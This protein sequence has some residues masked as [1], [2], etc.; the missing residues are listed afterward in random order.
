ME[1]KRKKASD[2]AVENS[3]WS[4]NEFYWLVLAVGAVCMTFRQF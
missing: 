3:Q 2:V 4:G 1:Q